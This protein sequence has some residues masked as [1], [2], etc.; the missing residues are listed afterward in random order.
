VRQ[1]LHRFVAAVGAYRRFEGDGCKLSPII[2]EDSTEDF[3]ESFDSL[4]IR[5]EAVLSSPDALDEPTTLPPDSC[6][7]S[8][9]GVYRETRPV[10]SALT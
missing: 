4:V 2:E 10:L 8:E 9:Y 7:T 3:A 6:K 5:P 1:N